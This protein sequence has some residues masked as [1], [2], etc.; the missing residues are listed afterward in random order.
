M[1][2]TRDIVDI[3]SITEK[4]NPENNTLLD[5]GDL[6]ITQAGNPLQ[7]FSG[8][9]SL[10]AAGL[11]AGDT[12]YVA[13]VNR[14]Y[15]S[16]GNGWYNVALVNVTPSL[17]I[18]PSGAISLNR[19]GTSTTITLTGQDSDTGSLTFSVESDGSFLGLGTIV[20][21][22]NGDVVASV[23]TTVKFKL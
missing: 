11:T 14:F 8:L 22:F 13:A 12:A 23:N 4:N 7:Y 21:D 5:S 1:S 9:D 20:Q 6:G 15:I 10:P 19:D 3:L 17:T 18:D 2:R 16:N